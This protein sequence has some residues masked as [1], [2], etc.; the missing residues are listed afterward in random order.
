MERIIILFCLYVV[1]L[2][3]A[4]QENMMDNEQVVNHVELGIEKTYNFE[5]E[6]AGDYYKKVR[7]AYPLHPVN[8]FFLALNLYWK[9]F[10]L[11]MDN[12]NS[13]EFIHQMSKCIAISDKMVKENPDDP[14][15]VFVNMVTKAFFMMFYADNKEYIE[16]MRLGR[17]SYPQF[18]KAFK[19]RDKIIDFCF[20][21]G[22]YNYY[23]EAYPELHP[24]YKPFVVFLRS[25]DKQAGLKQLKYAGKHGVF[26]KA[27]A[28][29]FLRH[30]YLYYE[31]DPVTAQK[32]AEKLVCMYPG[33]LQYL[34]NYLEILMIRENYDEARPLISKFLE[35][36]NEDYYKMK[37]YI[38]NGFYNE[39]VL[40]NLDM[41][42]TNYFLGISIAQDIGYPAESYLAYG[43]MGLSRIFIEEGNED[44]AKEYEKMARSISK[45]G[46]IDEVVEE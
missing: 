17:S 23:R 21:T 4:A 7:E 40:H 13:D 43:L 24:V 14:E 35:R 27:E 33:N 9:H 3:C 34:S 38:F 41:A 11:N 10:P 1:S 31:K 36:D 28:L 8:Y 37:A 39:K 26:L 20:V 18:K 46:Y 5:F 22:L 42:K 32:Y 16:V 15:T 25:G 2:F 12:P 29:F 6:K 44:K 30:I 19:M 45:Y